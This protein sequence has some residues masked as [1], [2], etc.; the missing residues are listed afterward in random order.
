MELRRPNQLTFPKGLREQNGFAS[1]AFLA[2]LPA[3]LAG[4][5]FFLYSQYFLKNWMQSLYICRT[6]LLETQSQTSHQLQ[7]LMAL[8]V[9]AT[10]L[11]FE[12][13][14]AEVELAMAIASENPPA[15][16]TAQAKINRIKHQ[17]RLLDQ[18]QRRIIASADQT[19]ARGLRE[20]EKSLRQQ[21]RWNQQHMP[22]MFS[23]KIHRVR[24]YPKKLAVRPDRPDVAPVYELESDFTRAQALNVS[25]TSEFQ[26][27]S[28]ETFQWIKNRH[29]KNQSCTASLKED[30]LSY[31]EVLSED[32]PSLRL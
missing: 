4:L 14:M 26:T 5:L 29:K 16:A 24:S 23:F 3:L 19:M 15:V 30:G 27:K 22:S 20:V 31:Q 17:Q 9:Q 18:R 7:S 2:I 28:R 25:W 10:R 12:L 6:E 11:R 8:N 32:R 21:D 13:H 1:I